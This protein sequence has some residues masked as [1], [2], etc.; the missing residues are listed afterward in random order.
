MCVD[1]IVDVDKVDKDSV[2]VTDGKTWST[3][4]ND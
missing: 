4:G 2:R 3:K 1:K